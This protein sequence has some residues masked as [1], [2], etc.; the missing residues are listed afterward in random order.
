MAKIRFRDSENKVV[1]DYPKA[2]ALS[3]CAERMVCLSQRDYYLLLNSIQF[4]GQF[5]NRVYTSRQAELYE[6]CSDEQWTTFQGWVEDLENHLG[7]WPMCQQALQDLVRTNRMIVAALMGQ[8]VNFETEGLPD[9]VNYSPG[10]LGA[11]QGISGALDD[12]LTLQEMKDLIEGLDLTGSGFL[13][14][15]VD[16]AQIL[17]FLILLFGPTQRVSV[18]FGWWDK[19]TFKRYQQ[20]SMAIAAHQATSLRGIM[21]GITPFSDSEDEDEANTWESIL[22]IPFLGKA[23]IAFLEPSPLG[24][25]G[26]IATIMGGKI[27]DLYR[28][29]KQVWDNWYFKWLNLV[30]EPEPTDSIT[31][32]LGVI[33]NRIATRE[34]AADNPNISV[35]NRLQVVADA[36]SEMELQGQNLEPVLAAIENILGGDYTPGGGE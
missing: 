26:I 17:S 19:F 9:A 10:I 29:V 18:A 4:I 32:A 15:L 35:V 12:G 25:A 5:R 16:I 27:A 8:S 7:E 14:T 6:I 21:R 36:L 22:N 34:D 13:D 33:A 30:E 24:E 1:F 11:I 2:E 20:N 31:A 28:K 23:V 3:D